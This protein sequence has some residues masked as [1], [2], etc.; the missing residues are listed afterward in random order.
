[1][2]GLNLIVSGGGF[3]AV[4]Y[5]STDQPQLS[6]GSGQKLTITSP[7]ALLDNRKQE[8]P[9]AGMERVSGRAANS[10]GHNIDQKTECEQG[11]DHEVGI[12]FH[13][14]SSPLPAQP[15]STGLRD[16]AV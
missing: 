12:D 7:C 9:R 3:F 13:G 6:C 10:Y 2:E 15:V 8:G 4:Y 1:M 11:E 14:R 16:G 5:K